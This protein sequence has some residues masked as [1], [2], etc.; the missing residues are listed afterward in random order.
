MYISGQQAQLLLDITTRQQLRNIVVKN[1]I[2]KKS[3][4]AGKPNL[5]LKEDIEKYLTQEKNRGKTK[6]DTK[7]IKTVKKKIET[8]KKTIK[9]NLEAR[10]SELDPPKP[11]TEKQKEQAEEEKE[12]TPLNKIGQDEYLRVEQELTALGTYES[13][14]RSILLFY[15]ISYQKYINAVTQSAQYDDVTMNDIGDLKVH[16]YFTIAKTCLAD[17]H[18]LARDMGIGVRNR[19]GVEVK[20]KKEKGIMDMM[21]EV[22]KDLL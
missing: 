3:Q 1:N 11:P 5:Y 13:V 6:A 21:L 14:D 15:A 17:M 8:K 10:P 7:K 2:G 22:D 18:K 19:I 9:K 16:P 12:F 20:K 4:G